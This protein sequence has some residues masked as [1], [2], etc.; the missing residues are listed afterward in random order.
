MQKWFPEDQ[1]SPDDYSTIY[2]ESF[3]SREFMGTL[4]NIG[5]TFANLTEDGKGVT[6]LADYVHTLFT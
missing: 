6:D 1:F 5:M 4:E 2:G 3:A